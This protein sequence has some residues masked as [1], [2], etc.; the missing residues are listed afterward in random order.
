[1]THE[2][3]LWVGSTILP[4]V[5]RIVRALIG[6][7]Y[8]GG[9]LFL[10]NP[11]NQNP[12]ILVNTGAV[13]TFG[14]VS[15][16][17]AGGGVLLSSSGVTTGWLVAHYQVPSTYASGAVLRN[18]FMDCGDIGRTVSGTLV[19]NHPATKDNRT[20]GTMVHRNI[21]LSTGSTVSIAQLFLS[22]STL[23]N[24]KIQDNNYVSFVSN[25]SGS[26]PLPATRD[27]VMKPEVREKYGR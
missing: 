24:T 9:S 23:T 11:T 27:C 13:M 22:G 10:G 20:T 4:S 14:T 18:L 12:S 8:L 1:M 3:L 19:I 25:Q 7:L 16:S 21:S 6:S 5:D 2:T 17:P 26:S 15:S